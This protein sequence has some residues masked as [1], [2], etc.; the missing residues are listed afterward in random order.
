[1]KFVHSITF[2]LVC[3]IFLLAQSEQRIA[4]QNLLLSLEGGISIGYTDYY[5][6][7]IGP[8]FRGSLKY[9]FYPH[10]NHR[11]SLGFQFGYQQIMGEDNRAI[12]VTK[13]GLLRDL[14]PS[15]STVIHSPGFFAD[16]NYLFSDRFSSFVRIGF[17][18]N[19]F[20][21]KDNNGN[22]ALGYQQGLY[23]KD[24]FTFIPEAGFEFRINERIGLSLAAN[25]A[26]PVTDYLDDVSAAIRKDS[27][28]NVLVGI[29]YSLMSDDKQHSQIDSEIQSI[30]EENS[31]IETIDESDN[32][33][34]TDFIQKQAGSV[35]PGRTLQEII[36]NSIAQID[37]N[38]ILLPADEI[39]RNGSAL[40]KPE[41][42]PELDRI[43]EILSNESNS[44]WRIEGHM[45]NQGQSAMI[46]KLS[47]DRAHA[48]YDYI[49]S[50]GVE[51]SRLRIYG[52]GD[53]FPIGDNSTA[54][55]RQLNRRIMLI[56]E[57][58]VTTEQKELSH[59]TGEAS[60][61]KT[62]V[63]EEIFN[64]FI[65]R[66]DDTF[67]SNTSSID[68]SAKFLLGEIVKYLL[69]QSESKWKVESY[70]DNQGS[71]N[72]QK[73][74]S[75]DRAKAIYD[76]LTEQG[77]SA[78]RLTFEGLGN[79][80]PIANNNTEEGRSTNRRVLIIRED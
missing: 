63:S 46:K 50:K 71:E 52:L 16:Y 48:L 79:T 10:I 44:R 12:I 60:E 34:I 62:T 75:Y 22:D 69:E 17:T 24:F 38:E 66:C 57:K 70:T 53:N 4:N 31:N 58:S 49:M 35:L 28:L 32:Q 1:M 7:K 36:N 43:I 21:P 40:I 76:Y 51:V 20:N 42:Y 26:F 56:K 15:F 65:L 41:I 30:S 80:S 18:Y 6:Q 61:E 47:Q 72:F 2:I 25:Y 14:P 23:N 64:Q 73:K 5:K 55:G 3:N 8:A 13:A 29:S 27:Y 77:I 68:E 39:F 67:E 74:L 37:V 19:T 45:D 59:D 11:I 9:F 78:D 33:I 54:E